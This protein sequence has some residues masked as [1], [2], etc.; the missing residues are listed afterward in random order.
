MKKSS[1]IKSLAAM[2]VL[3]YMRLWDQ[4]TAA[5]VDQFVANSTFIARRIKKAYRRDAEVIYPPIDSAAFEFCEEKEDY[6]LTASRLV[7]Y[8]NV[9]MVV[10]AF[11]R[12]PERRLVVI[13]DGPDMQK[14]RAFNF[15]NVTIMGYQPFETLR[16]YMQHARAFVFAAEEDFGI[17]PVEAQSCGTPVIAYGK[18]GALET[19]RGIHTPRPTGLFFTEQTPEAI[20][21]AVDEFER[22]EDAFVP[23]DCREN[24]IRFSPERFRQEFSELVERH[25]LRLKGA[26]IF[27][28]VPAPLQHER[29]VYLDTAQYRRRSVDHE[30]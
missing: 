14:I 16:K 29:R 23:S 2:L 13:G 28:P 1:G 27:S 9:P 20:C 7:P 17:V 5:G 11:G 26:S 21:N 22:Y 8:K 18:G 19:I 3:H 6:Y 10:E 12:T 30:P 25:Y 15:P 24:A 4:R